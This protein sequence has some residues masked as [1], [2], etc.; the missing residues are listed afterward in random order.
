M[1][2][3]KLTIKY[4]VELEGVFHFILSGRRKCTCGNGR[5]RTSLCFAVGLPPSAASLESSGLLKLKMHT[6][7]LDQKSRHSFV[8]AILH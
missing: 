7:V 5:L 3:K 2:L 1:V 6:S 8:P 4:K